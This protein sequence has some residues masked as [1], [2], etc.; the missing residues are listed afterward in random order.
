MDTINGHDVV[1]TVVA[2]LPDGNVL[3]GWNA[4]KVRNRIPAQNMVVNFKRLIG[5]LYVLL[6]I[7]RTYSG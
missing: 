4:L 2:F 3:V 6:F 7:P 1:P 5:K